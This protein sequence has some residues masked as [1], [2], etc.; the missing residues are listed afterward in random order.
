MCVCRVLLRCQQLLMTASRSCHGCMTPVPEFIDP[1]FRENKPKALVF[2]HW[3]R[4]FWAFRENCFYNFGHRQYSL[5][6]ALNAMQCAEYMYCQG[7]MTPG[8]TSYGMQQTPCTM[9][10]RHA[11]CVR[12]AICV[13]LEKSALV[14]KHYS[15][16]SFLSASLHTFI[17]TVLHTW[18]LHYLTL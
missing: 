18:L 8:N 14:N 10:R 5:R 16:C 6:N 1:R 9:C 11:L 2:S 7:S 15:I 12:H 17:Y 3:K 13:V 4:A